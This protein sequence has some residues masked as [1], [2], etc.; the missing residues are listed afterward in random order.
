MKQDATTVCSNLSELS[1]DEKREIWIKR[2]GL[3]VKTL[4]EVAGVTASTFSRTLR[5]PTMPV[6][7]HRSLVN[8]GVPPDLLPTPFD[9]KPGPKP[10]GLGMNNT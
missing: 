8:F 6:E 5:K 9:Q 7:Q 3:T 10:R 2:N 1:P 4:A